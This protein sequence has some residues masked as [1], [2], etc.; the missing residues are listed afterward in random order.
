VA[1]NALV[2]EPREDSGKGVARK[3]RAAGKIPGVF[4]GNNVEPRHISVDPRAVQTLLEKSDAGM[5]TLFNISIVG[6]PGE[7]LGLVKDIQRDPITSRY[8]HLDLLRLD[9]THRIHVTVPVHISGVAVG[10]KME[11]GIMDQSMRELDLECLPRAIP[12]E[13]LADVSALDVG[14]TLHVRDLTIPDGVKLLN[15]P[16]LPVVSVVAPTVEEVTEAAEEG[17]A[18]EAAA[19]GAE[20]PA[21]DDSKAKEESTASSSD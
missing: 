13:I 6:E 14:D 18:A 9:V 21:G 16:D 4:Y 5:N 10:V 8:L 2:V 19:E 20:A 1:D 12:Q 7:T 11:G 15:D 17:E 3:L